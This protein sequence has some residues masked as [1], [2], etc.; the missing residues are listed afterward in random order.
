MFSR[1][2]PTVGKGGPSLKMKKNAK[3]NP[4]HIKRLMIKRTQND[5]SPH[6][7][8]LIVSLENNLLIKTIQST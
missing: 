6:E 8:S 3:M 2:P 7:S 4:T 5:E 1:E